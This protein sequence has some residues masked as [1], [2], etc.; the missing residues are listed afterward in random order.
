MPGSEWSNFVKKGLSPAN[1]RN[2]PTS[3]GRLYASEARTNDLFPRRNYLCSPLG[4]YM[5]PDVLARARSARAG[6]SM[7]RSAPT[8]LVPRPS[9]TRLEGSR[10]RGVSHASGR[11]SVPPSSHARP[12][13]NSRS[14]RARRSTA[15][16]RKPRPALLGKAGAIQDQDPGALR[17]HFPQ[18]SPHH[19][20]LP[21]RMRDE[22]LKRLI[23][24][25][26]GVQETCRSKRDPLRRASVECPETRSAVI[27]F[28]DTGGIRTRC[29]P[30]AV[31]TPPDSPS[32]SPSGS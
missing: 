16:R 7:R 26:V 30:D 10:W 6:P 27:G 24:S 18:P 28:W 21:R 1:F 20:R 2:R 8:F 4:M 23:G 9:I 25:A 22:V 17:H 13:G 11:Y 29:D 19:V 5:H 15:A 31:D 14:S 12:S 32:N 3:G